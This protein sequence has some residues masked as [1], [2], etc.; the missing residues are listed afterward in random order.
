MPMTFEQWQA[1]RRRVEDM[2][3]DEVYAYDFDGPAYIYA[4]GQ[5]LINEDGTLLVIV[6]NDD[7][8]GAALDVAE[9]YLWENW[10]KYEVGGVT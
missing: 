7:W 2:R 4:E 8:H 5:I 10:A 3:N 6:A 1:T 9:R